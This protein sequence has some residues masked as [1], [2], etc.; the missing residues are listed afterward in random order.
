MLCRDI[1]APSKGQSDEAASLELCPGFSLR[2]AERLVTVE[3]DGIA[4]FFNRA[5]DVEGC[6]VRHLKLL[7]RHSYIFIAVLCMLVNTYNQ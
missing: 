4:E 3:G 6:K 1:K 5:E 2:V 7:R